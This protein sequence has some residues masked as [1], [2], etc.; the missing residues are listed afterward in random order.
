LP[1]KDFYYH[2]FADTP[3]DFEIGIYSLNVSPT[4]VGL[5]AFAPT[6]PVHFTLGCFRRNESVRSTG[7]AENPIA[8][9]VVK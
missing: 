2:S 7:E 5:A 4:V 3:F 1:N 9:H 8:F 6:S